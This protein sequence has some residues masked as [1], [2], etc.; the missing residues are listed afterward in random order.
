MWGNKFWWE[1]HFRAKSCVPAPS[2]P[3]SVLAQNKGPGTEAHFSNSPR[4]LRWAS[5]P[6][7]PPGAIFRS[8]SVCTCT[9][10]RAQHAVDRGIGHCSCNHR[11]ICLRCPPSCIRLQ[12]CA[13]ATT[14][15]PRPCTRGGGAGLRRVGGACRGRAGVRRCCRPRRCG[16]G[17]G[18]TRTRSMGTLSLPP[19]LSPT[20]P[21]SLPPSLH[22]RLICRVVGDAIV[23][24]PRRPVSLKIG[25]QI[26]NPPS[27]PPSQG[28]PG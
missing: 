9:H 20:S 10:Y 17:S 18:A 7:P 14:T 25:P 28:Q 5:M 4:L 22:G 11:P 24:H 2:A 15:V 27:L 19:S 16:W 3:T 13:T 1:K 12:F 23:L 21:P 8:P 6:P 26:Q